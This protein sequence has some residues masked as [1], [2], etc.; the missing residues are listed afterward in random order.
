[1]LAVGS[2]FHRAVG[3]AES[4]IAKAAGMGQ[5]WLQGIGAARRLLQA[6]H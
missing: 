1:V 6:N 2:D 4:L 5:R 3:T